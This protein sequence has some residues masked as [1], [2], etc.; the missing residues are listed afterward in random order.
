MPPVILYV[1]SFAGAVSV[2][3]WVV[4]EARRINAELHP[5]PACAGQRSDILATKRLRRDDAGVYR[6]E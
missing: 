5:G 2:A 1:F 4:R 3:R 6:P